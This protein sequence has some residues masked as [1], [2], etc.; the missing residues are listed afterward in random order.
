VCLGRSLREICADNISD[1]EKIE[2]LLNT[3]EPSLC[4]NRM[5]WL[6]QTPNEDRSVI[7]E[8]LQ[9][10]PTDCATKEL[11]GMISLMKNIGFFP[12]AFK[13]YWIGHNSD[14]SKDD[15][16]CYRIHIDVHNESNFRR[17]QQQIGR[18]HGLWPPY[19]GFFVDI[20]LFTGNNGRTAE[21]PKV[22][23]LQKSINS[24]LGSN[25]L[26]ETG[27]ADE[28]SN[29]MLKLNF[30]AFKLRT[31]L[32]RDG[33]SPLFKAGESA[34]RT[35]YR[36]QLRS[37]GISAAKQE[38]LS[39]L[40]EEWA[41]YITRKCR[42][43]QLPCSTYLEEAEPFLEQ[44]ANRSDANLALIVAAGSL[45]RE[46]ISLSISDEKDDQPVDVHLKMK[47][48]I[49][50]FAGMPGCL[51]SDLCK[52]ILNSPA[53]L[54]D[55]I[56]VHYMQEDLIKGKY[57]KKVADERRKQPSR[58]TLVDKNAPN[59]A[60]WIQIEEMCRTTDCCYSYYT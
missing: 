5:D 9:A 14:S 48:L 6:G 51:N 31:S 46:E 11:Q 27:L 32:I 1:K 18:S 36:R 58:V 24:T 3:V 52:A 4:P 42:D 23:V 41:L 60:V 22:D 44:Y 49:V 45:V 43:E 50:F 56:P 28:D 21:L 2:M 54:G 26:A 19:R 20:N 13:C 16:R 40:L 25:S 15:N 53:C 10:H 17:Y 35:F 38:E 33:L 39:K 47:G 30:L 59:E 8:F 57:W 55:N 37:W 34:Y 7:I 12:A 29:L